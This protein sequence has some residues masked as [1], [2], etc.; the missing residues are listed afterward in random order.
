MAA[1]MRTGKVWT[2]KDADGQ[3]HHRLLLD[4]GREE[5]IPFLEGLSAQRSLIVLQD[6]VEAKLGEPCQLTIMDLLTAYDEADGP[7]AAAWHGRARGQTAGAP[8][9]VDGPQ[10]TPA[11]TRGRSA[12]PRTT[13]LF[14]KPAS[15]SVR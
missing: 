5:I 1:M 7:R 6:A 2:R 15:A 4:D 12:H 13:R 11:G 9:G 3:K 10:R 14:H 8:M